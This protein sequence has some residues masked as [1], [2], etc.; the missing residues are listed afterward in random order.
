[1][2]FDDESLENNKQNNRNQVFI[3]F[4]HFAKNERMDAATE[5]KLEALDAIENAGH[6]NVAAGVRR[7][8]SSLGRLFRKKNQ[9][10][11]SM[12]CNDEK[13]G[14]FQW[15]TSIFRR[16]E[17]AEKPKPTDGV[18]EEIELA[19]AEAPADDVTPSDI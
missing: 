7:K 17:G 19:R 10:V 1:L 5:S 9:S 16:K 8:S 13:K 12:A 15:F 2:Y 11:E 4:F 14:V 3:G 6:D 18:D